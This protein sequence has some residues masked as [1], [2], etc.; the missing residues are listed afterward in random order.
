MAAT[1]IVTGAVTYREKKGSPEW[2][3]VKSRS[4]DNWELPKSDVR[5][6]ESSVSAILRYMKESLGIK[7]SVLEEASRAKLTVSTNGTP[8]E[9]NLFFYIM[10]QGKS[11]PDELPIATAISVEGE[12]V[13]FAIAKRRLELVREQKALTEAHNY[14]KQWEK[15][16]TKR[17]RNS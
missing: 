5:G 4:N 12:W 3:I 6:G 11:T 2:Y 10:R 17:K 7:A 13:S 15:A 9:Q 8:T 16:K 1:K 14:L